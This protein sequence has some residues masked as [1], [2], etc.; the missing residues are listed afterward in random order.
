MSGQL[1]LR[2]TLRDEHKCDGCPCVVWGEVKSYCK[3][4]NKDLER[5]DTKFSIDSLRLPD[6]LNSQYQ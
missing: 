6:C 4:F 5:V 1:V 2:V 3:W